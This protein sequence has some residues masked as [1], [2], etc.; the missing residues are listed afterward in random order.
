M[1]CGWNYTNYGWSV[2][3]KKI[4]FHLM[5]LRISELV[6]VDDSDIISMPSFHFQ[7]PILVI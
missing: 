1:F 2:G 4:D 3:E 6:E 7:V 5:V